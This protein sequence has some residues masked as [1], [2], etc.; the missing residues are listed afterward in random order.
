M[1]APAAEYWP[2]AQYAQIGD[3]DCPVN[4]VYEPAAQFAQA[5][6]PVIC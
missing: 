5:V 1:L 3:D 4:A 6:A 2:E